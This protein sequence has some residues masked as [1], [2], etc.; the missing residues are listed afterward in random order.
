MSKKEEYF[1]GEAH[2]R[3]VTVCVLYDTI[4]GKFYMGMS[5]CMP[6]DEVK[7]SLG[8]EIAKGRAQ[9]NK[10][11]SKSK[12]IMYGSSSHST[13]KIKVDK[14]LENDR[15]FLKQI[16]R[17]YFFDFKHNPQKYIASYGTE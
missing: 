6:E 2:D 8:E 3:F 1:E 4:W 16:A 12:M 14:V 15:F 10:G 11:N 7:R 5:I 9:S 13:A 17:S